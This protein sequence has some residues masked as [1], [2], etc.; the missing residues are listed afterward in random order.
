[1]LSLLSVQWIA[2]SHPDYRE[3]STC[4]G[5]YSW[6]VFRIGGISIDYNQQ[7]NIYE[8]ADL[9]RLIMLLS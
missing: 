5:N 3:G 4:Q 9:L 6:Y 7:A 8:A 2:Q 1:M